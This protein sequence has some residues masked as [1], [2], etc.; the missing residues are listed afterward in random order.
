MSSLC[1]IRFINCTATILYKEAISLVE[2]AEEKRLLQAAQRGDAEA[3]ASL[4][5]DNVQ[6]IYRYIYYRVNDRQL[7]EDLTSDVFMRAMKGLSRYTDQGKPFVAWLYRIAHD[8][9]IDHRRRHNR[10]QAEL[11]IAD[12][13]LPT[14]VDMDSRLVRKQAARGLRMAIAKLTDEQQQVI[15]LRFMEGYSLE[16]TASAM[17]KKANAIK[18]LQ[19]RAI[20]ALGR[21][22][23]REGFPIDDILAGLS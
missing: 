9:V 5:R 19:H 4:Y 20:R 21:Q 22:L 6:T 12:R 11:D 7:A 2:R 10:R 18:A 23:D 3:F 14:E 17:N 15:I 1:G 13:P 8:R 16:E